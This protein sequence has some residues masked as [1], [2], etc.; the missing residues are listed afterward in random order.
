MRP[1]ELPGGAVK[2]RRSIS[3]LR[4]FISACFLIGTTPF[5][6]TLATA[7]EGN[8]GLMTMSL[9]ELL[10]MEV[11]TASKKSE[12][13]TETPAFTHVITKDQI[14]RFGYRTVAEALSGVIGFHFNSDL[15]YDSMTVRGFGI[16]GDF[17][18][19]ILILIDGQRTNDAV[20]DWGAV[21]HDFVFDIEG[22]KRIEIVKG[23]GSALWGNNALLGVVNIVPEKGADIDGVEAGIG[24]SSLY[25]LKAFVKAGK[26]FDNGFEIAGM[27]S[28]LR[29]E[30]TDIYVPD[31]GTAE[32][33]NEWDAIRSY[34]QASYKAFDINLM[35]S[36][37]SRTVP[38]GTTTTIGSTATR[39]AES[40]NSP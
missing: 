7:A 21:G 29:T 16:V 22:I 38:T 14:Q 25:E 3:A 40:C 10:N 19:R 28:G 24:E 4:L 11:T 18:N 2:H 17:Q 30:S 39:G 5:Q 35:A 8:P 34:L 36:Q 9:E 1:E 26:K 15:V 20:E 27:F 33:N 31:R 12:T 13:V 32:D 23:P 37:L 6:S